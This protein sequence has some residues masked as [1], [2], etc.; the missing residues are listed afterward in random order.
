M[1]HLPKTIM[2]IGVAIFVVGFLMQFIKRLPGDIL[3]KKGNTTFYFPIMTSIIVSILLS[4]FFYIISR[5]K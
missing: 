4:V 2:M 3:L 5:F 1:N